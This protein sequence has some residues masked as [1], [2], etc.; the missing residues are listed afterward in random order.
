MNFIRS[1]QVMLPYGS[2]RA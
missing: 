2:T 1:M